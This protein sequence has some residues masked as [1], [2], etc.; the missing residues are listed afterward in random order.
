MPLLP[1]CH[2]APPQLWYFWRRRLFIWISFMDS[3]FEILLYV[4]PHSLFISGL[5]EVVVAEG[6]KRTLE[7]RTQGQGAPGFGTRG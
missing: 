7:G 1:C 6:T 3:Y 4:G 5:G 2:S